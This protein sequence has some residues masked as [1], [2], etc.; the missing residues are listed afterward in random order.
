MTAATPSG[1]GQQ[2]S[3]HTSRPLDRSRCC[4]SQERSSPMKRDLRRTLS[5]LAVTG[6]MLVAMPA[7]GYAQELAS[8]LTTPPFVVQQTDNGNDNVGGTDQGSG[9]GGI[10][11][12]ND[13]RAFLRSAV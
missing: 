8:S 1:V 12:L 3:G 13:H 2:S 10:I 6:A 11:V 9:G 7:P 5:S 4:Q